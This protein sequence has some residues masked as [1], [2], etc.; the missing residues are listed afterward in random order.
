RLPA[1]RRSAAP[2]RARSASTTDRNGTP[3]RGAGSRSTGRGGS[4]VRRGGALLTDF[5]PERR[6]ALAQRL[7][8]GIACAR[9]DAHDHVHRRD[10]VLMKTEGLANDAADAVA[11][12]GAARGPHRSRAPEARA[13]GLIGRNGQRTAYVTDP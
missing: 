8:R 3:G 1:R 7:R 4:G 2:L 6:E 10:R 13:A 5:L 12:H 9:P 11:R